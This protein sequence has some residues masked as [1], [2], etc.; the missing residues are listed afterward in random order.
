[1]TDAPLILVVEDEPGI[2]EV[3]EAYLRR[4]GFCT[5]WARDGRQAVE[6]WRARRPA[7]VVLDVGLPGMDGH[8]VLAAIRRRE[9]TPVIFLTARAEELDRLLGL[10]LGADD[11]VVKPASP[12]EVVA[13][14]HAVLRRSAAAAPRPVPVVEVGP[15][16]VDGE[17]MEARAGGRP[18]GL[19]PTEFR[20]LAHMA[21]RPRRVFSRAELM[22]ACL[23]TSDAFDRVVDSHVTGL[24][25]KL[26]EAGLDD[27]LVAVRGAGYRLD[28]GDGAR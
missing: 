27:V 14:V 23:P 15:V 22:D 8:E 10:K 6:L 5:A 12:R 28:L 4:D 25:R 26:R 20:L 17:A 7:L 18:L 2:A 21:A 9:D 13:R 3:I 1:V 16:T 24:R 19:T 11:Y